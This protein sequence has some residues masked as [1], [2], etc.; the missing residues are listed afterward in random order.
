MASTTK[1]R[2]KTL[3]RHH[4]YSI[5]LFGQRR[6]QQYTPLSN[7]NEGEEPALEIISTHETGSDT[8]VEERVDDR[9]T[10]RRLAICDEL[11]KTIFFGKFSLHKLRKTLVVENRLEELGLMR[12]RRLSI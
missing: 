11:E 4:S 10:K 2:R 3:F 5:G 7:E 6:G 8:L 12:P 9:R 1:S